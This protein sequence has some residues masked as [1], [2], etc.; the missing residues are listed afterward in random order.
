MMTGIGIK[1]LL[2][3]QSQSE[4]ETILIQDMMNDQ[5]ILTLKSKVSEFSRPRSCLGTHFFRQG[6]FR[7]QQPRLVFSHKSM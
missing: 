7:L 3:Y 5:Q 6:C 2:L 4:F 1:S